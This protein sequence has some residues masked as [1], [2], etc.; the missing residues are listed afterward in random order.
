MPG[1]RDKTTAFEY[2]Y[3]TLSSRNFSGEKR[4]R[5]GSAWRADHLG[6]FSSRVKLHK[7]QPVSF[8]ASNHKIMV[9]DTANQV[10]TEGTAVHPCSVR[11]CIDLPQHLLE[12]IMVAEAA[13]QVITEVRGLYFLPLSLLLLLLAGVA[14]S[15]RGS[16]P[17]DWPWAACSHH[18]LK[19]TK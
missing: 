11:S 13:T 16:Q 18:S 15:E 10:I 5:H 14:L 3:R 1:R 7:E 17:G 9:P 12:Q 2:V 19:G 4:N 6:S 8:V